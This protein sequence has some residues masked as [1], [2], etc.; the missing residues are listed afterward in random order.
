MVA[1]DLYPLDPDVPIERRTQHRWHVNGDGSLCLM[2]AADD[3]Q[4]ENHGRR[5]RP[6]GR[7]LVHRVSARRGGRPRP[8]DR[9]R[10][11]RQRRARRPVGREVRVSD[12]LIV[13][14]Q[15]LR[16]QDPHLPAEERL[17]RGQAG[18]RRT[19]LRHRRLHPR[20]R[21]GR[22]TRRVGL[23]QGSLPRARRSRPARRLVRGRPRPALRRHRGTRQDR[24]AA[25]PDLQGR[26]RRPMARP[27]PRRRR[28]RRLLRTDQ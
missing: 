24:V 20:T 28:A 13:A 25:A 14:A 2:Q 18:R 1:P 23:G 19:A 15:L 11:L 22:Q 4:P 17:H 27:Q 8:D 10:H 26:D 7:G 9:A 5:P 12:P 6:Q 16:R 21:P 3:W